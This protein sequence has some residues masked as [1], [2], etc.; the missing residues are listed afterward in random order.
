MLTTHIKARKYFWHFLN[1]A[2]FIW[3]YGSADFCFVLDFTSFCFLSCIRLKAVKIQDTSYLSWGTSPKLAS[4]SLLLVGVK[5]PPTAV[6]PPLLLLLPLLHGMESFGGVTLP[7][8]GC[9]DVLV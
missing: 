7:C 3:F 1:F 9:V 8:L 5:A 6:G 2:K 4:G